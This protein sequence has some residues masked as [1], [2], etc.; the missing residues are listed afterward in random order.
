MQSLRTFV[1]E[2]SCMYINPVFCLKYSLVLIPSF[3]RHVV[4]TAFMKHAMRR[5]RDFIW[6]QRWDCLTKLRRY[7]KVTNGPIA[8]NEENDAECPVTKRKNRREMRSLL[9]SRCDGNES[10]ENGYA[11]VRGTTIFSQHVFGR[12]CVPP[13][14]RLG[15]H[16]S[17]RYSFDEMC[18]SSV[19]RPHQPS[20]IGS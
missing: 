11:P 20:S 12:G 10:W 4:I 1:Y 5:W 7:C 6:W 3:R 8:N 15:T 19:E 17:K 16:Q 2:R 13:I 18:H 14:P 9:L